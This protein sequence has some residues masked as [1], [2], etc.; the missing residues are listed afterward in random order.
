MGQY[1]H[2]FLLTKGYD[3]GL[4][5]YTYF[6]REKVIYDI[7]TIEELKKV[8]ELN[9]PY[10]RE[11]K[12]INY[13][14]KCLYYLLMLTGMRLN[15]A[16]TLKTSDFM[17]DKIV[18]RETKTDTQRIIPNNPLLWR[19]IKK[20]PKTDYV[21]VGNM[22]GHMG[23]SGVTTDLRARTQKLK[24]KK[25]IYPHLFRHQFCITMLQNNDVTMVSK[26]MGHDDLSSTLTYTHYLFEDMTN[27][28]MTHPLLRKEQ[29]LQTIGERIKVTISKMIDSSIYTISYKQKPSIIS[30][31]IE[32]C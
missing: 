21:F 28:V 17:R 26:L 29:N 3:S 10:K 23:Q 8:A 27:A 4:S 2:E 6:K 15:E 7:P 14:F 16:L 9:Y 31:S 19:L 18:V 32:K 20:L 12:K 22:E 11:R 1:I 30:F 5:N 24:I 13:R 25:R